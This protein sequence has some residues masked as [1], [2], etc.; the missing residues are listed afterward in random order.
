MKTLK[1]KNPAVS[2]LLD[3]LLYAALISAA[4]LLGGLAMHTEAVFSPALCVVCP[5]L[6]ATLARL[7]A[8][9][10]ERKTRR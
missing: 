10:T 2:F 3:V 9:L 7:T 6:C 1:R 4:A 5:I 8:R